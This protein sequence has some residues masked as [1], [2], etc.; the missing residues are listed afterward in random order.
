[1]G[2]GLVLLLTV[3]STYLCGSVCF[4]GTDKPWKEPFR[5][6]R[7]WW[8]RNVIGY[9][10]ASYYAN[11]VDGAGR[12]LTHVLKSHVWLRGREAP[13]KMAPYALVVQLG[14]WF[15]KSYVSGKGYRLNFVHEDWA[16]LCD[17]GKFYLRH[18]DGTCFPCRSEQE[19]LDM[20]EALS[21]LPAGYIGTFTKL[22]VER[23]KWGES[24]MLYVADISKQRDQYQSEREKLLQLGV[25]TIVRL[26][27]TK[28][29]IKSREAMD[30]REWLVGEVQP[31]L[32]LDALRRAELIKGDTHRQGWQ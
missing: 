19:V 4:L 32:D 3:I 11:E 15:S 23:F 29:F 2:R 17:G 9:R 10:Q 27:G 25:E 12:T 22:I 16:V 7:E 18:K 8:L 24:T 28:R 21:E 26:D 1:M 20:L 14:G 6:I 5:F 30:I 13:E 31:Y